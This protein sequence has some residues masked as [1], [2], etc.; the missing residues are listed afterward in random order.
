MIEHTTHLHFGIFWN[1]E[2]VAGLSLRR[3]LCNTN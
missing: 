3:N 2:G 1:A